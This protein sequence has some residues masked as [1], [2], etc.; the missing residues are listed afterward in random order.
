MPEDRLRLGIRVLPLTVH[1]QEECFQDGV[2]LSPSQ[3]YDKLDVADELPK[4]SM[5]SP[6]VFEEAFSEA[7]AE[8]K[9]VF[10]L[11]ISSGLSGTYQAACLAQAAFG[12]KVTV[13]DSKSAS[14]GLGL[15]VTEA[16]KLQAQGLSAREIAEAMAAPIAKSKFFAAVDTLKYLRKGGRI[17]AT[18]AFVGGMLGI[19]PVVSIVDGLVQS[20]GKARGMAAAIDFI[21]KEMKKTLPDLAH[22]VMF[23]HASAPQLM[24]TAIA[25]IKPALQ[26]TE[27]L[28]CEVGATIGTYA[29]RGCVG[30]AY[31]AQENP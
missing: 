4:T 20:A 17:S 30:I 26:L 12:D 7:I 22:G 11:L 8:G 13:V 1:F 6:A 19:K 29:G 27:H 23:A 3:F 21:C 24:E 2:D 18:G 10:C 16:V 9:E 15:L 25:K 28:C 31:I 14:L 5:V